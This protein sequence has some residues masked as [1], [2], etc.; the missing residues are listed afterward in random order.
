MM[1]AGMSVFSI[2]GLGLLM[3]LEINVPLGSS[4]LYGYKHV[5]TSPMESLMCCIQFRLSVSSVA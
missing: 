3:L 4:S 1:F 2:M 5:F